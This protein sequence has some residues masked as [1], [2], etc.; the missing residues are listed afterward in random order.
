MKRKAKTNLPMTRSR[1]GRGSHSRRTRNLTAC[2][3]NP[4]LQAESFD[5][6]LNAS[7]YGQ[8][9]SPAYR[10][11]RHS[12]IMSQITDFCFQSF[13]DFHQR[14]HRRRFLSALN[15]ANENSRE[16]SHFGQLLL[17]ETGPGIELGE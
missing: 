3:L 5:A 7:F 16:V 15:A 12:K 9:T 14:I 1:F 8:D 13:G 10:T 11:G 4:I 6:C 17:A 2:Q